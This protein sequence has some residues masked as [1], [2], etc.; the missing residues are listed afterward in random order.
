M[1][2]LFLTTLLIFSFCL[3]A[4]AQADEN[5][6]VVSKQSPVLIAQ[7][8]DTDV[9]WYKRTVD[10]LGLAVLKN[11]PVMGLI[12]IKNDRNFRQRL[13]LLRTGFIFRQVPL[14]RATF[15]IVEEQ[16][17]QTEVFVLANC[18]EMPKCEDCIVIRG[19]DIDRIEKLFIPKP[20]TRK[21]KKQ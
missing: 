7:F 6:D 21:R 14:S 17:H 2:R 13:N 9:E 1:R 4:V 19:I 18:L 3:A 8:N 5:T 12:R 15:L 16:K 10:I 11:P 20:T